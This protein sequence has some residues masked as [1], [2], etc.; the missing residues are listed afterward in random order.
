MRIFVSGSRRKLPSTIFN[1]FDGAA[2]QL[3]IEIARRGHNVSVLSD[4]DFTVD[5][6]LVAGMAEHG[7]LSGRKPVVE[8][9]R[10]SGGNRIY[11]NEHHVTVEWVSYQHPDSRDFRLGPR[12]GAI[13]NANIVLLMGGDTGTHIVGRLA[14]DVRKPVVAI[15]SFGGAAEK[16]FTQ[17]E[18]VYRQRPD[19]LGK[20]TCLH[21]VW[22]EKRSA[23]EV[24]KLMEM[25]GGDHS[26]FI[27]YAHED[28]SAA[29]HVEV[30]LR[31]ANRTVYR[32]EHE[33][34]VGDKLGKTIESLISRA[35]TFLL[36]WSAKSSRSK[37]C[38]Q[39]L[40]LALKNQQKVGRSYRSVLLV[41]DR[42]PIP[43]D[44]EDSLQPIGTDRSGRSEAVSQI[45]R[46]E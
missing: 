15:G 37:W 1:K 42:T 17:L 22:N 36:L 12:V 6:N 21:Q 45:L 20:F 31:R 19:T 10:T 25:L 39:E 26:Y 24:V 13:S 9:H 11:E 14:M 28:S 34:R 3:G 46:G 40:S 29:N 32:D 44:F 43:S 8:V 35:N 16:V 5:F 7:T 4:R 30:L 2:R 38:Q 41:L 33:L 18:P 27:S 23:A